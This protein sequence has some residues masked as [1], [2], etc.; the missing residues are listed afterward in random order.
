MQLQ[1]AMDTCIYFTD[2]TPYLYVRK[3]NYAGNTS[4]TNS[5]EIKPNVHAYG[6]FVG[7]EPADYDL[8][9]R[10]QAN[11]AATYL[12]RRKVDY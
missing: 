5:F 10:T 1:E 4:S 7:N 6:G 11:M 9:N 3:G 2:R 12:V 8:N